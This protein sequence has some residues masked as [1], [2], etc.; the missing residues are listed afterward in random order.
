MTIAGKLPEQ[1]ETTE[2]KAAK[3]NFS[4]HPELL[5]V[6]AEAA[7]IEKDGSLEVL[8]VPKANDS[9]FDG[10]DCSVHALVSGQMEMESG[11]CCV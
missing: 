2:V 5:W 4:V 6:E 3:G 1:K 11:L 7:A 8:S 9:S 10:H